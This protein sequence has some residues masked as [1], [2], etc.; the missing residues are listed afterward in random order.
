MTRT[1]IEDAIEI[2]GYEP[3][4]RVPLV[5]VN[6]RLKCWPRWFDEISRGRKMFDVRFCG[7]RT[8]QAGDTL[9]LFRFD[10]SASG[11]QPTPRHE[12]PGSGFFV[13]VMAVYH[14]LPGLQPDHCV[15]SI[16]LPEWR[17]RND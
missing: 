11:N 10:P 12:P 17:R 7:D 14:N 1:P 16:E 4:V 2:P 3:P 8:F 6:H 5:Q 15:L 13:H 9:E